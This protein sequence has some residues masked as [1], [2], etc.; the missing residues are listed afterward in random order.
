M[1]SQALSELH[2]PVCPAWLKELNTLARSLPETVPVAELDD[3]NALVRLAHY[4]VGAALD[5][6]A[7]SD[8]WELID[9]AIDNAIG[10]GRSKGYLTG[11]VRTG[12]HG[13]RRLCL[14]FEDCVARYS[15]NPVLLEPWV[16]KL[17]AILA[18]W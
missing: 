8:P 3:D 16:N 12:E 7:D 9:H 14:W 6:H 11:L 15:I 10:Y 13:V 4:D 18:A 2:A 1:S 17:C 5:R